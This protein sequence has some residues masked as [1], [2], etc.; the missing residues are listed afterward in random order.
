MSGVEASEEPKE[1]QVHMCAT[2]VSTV[3]QTFNHFQEQIVQLNGDKARLEG[4]LRRLTEEWERQKQA[5]ETEIKALEEKLAQ[6]K[7]GH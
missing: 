5:L 6:L 3:V 1:S 2:C 7:K 4:E